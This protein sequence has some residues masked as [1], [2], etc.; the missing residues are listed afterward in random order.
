MCFRAFINFSATTSVFF[1]SYY[2]TPLSP[3]RQWQRTCLH[4]GKLFQLI[5]QLPAVRQGNCPSKIN[6]CWSSQAKMGQRSNNYCRKNKRLCE[7]KSMG[8]GPDSAFP[9]WFKFCI[10]RRLAP[11]NREQQWSFKSKNVSNWYIIFWERMVS[12]LWRWM[13]FLLFLMNKKYLMMF[14]CTAIRIA[15]AAP[16]EIIR[17]LKQTDS[18][19]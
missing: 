9:Y 5:V 12:Y 18:Y 19:T 1:C 14:T 3:F 15:F 16:W 7:N 17:K 13:F 4:Q 11:H 8:C 10:C 2:W 6:T